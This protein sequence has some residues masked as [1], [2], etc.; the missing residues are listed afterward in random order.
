M[1]FFV[2]FCWVSNFVLALLSFV[3]LCEV[4]KHPL[5]ITEKNLCVPNQSRIRQR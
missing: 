2:D 1:L 4:L 5:C 3:I